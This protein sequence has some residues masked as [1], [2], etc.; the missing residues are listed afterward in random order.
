M[1]SRLRSYVQGTQHIEETDVEGPSLMTL[2]S[3]ADG[4]GGMGCFAR[5]VAAS[6]CDGAVS[7]RLGRKVGLFF[8]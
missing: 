2:M 8:F 7:A 6:G 5:R 1:I 3:A 4:T